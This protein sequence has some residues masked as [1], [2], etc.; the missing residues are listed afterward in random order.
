MP[1]NSTWFHL[2]NDSSSHVYCVTENKKLTKNQIKKGAE[3][4]KI[5]SKKSGKVIF[6]K[7]NNL[8]RVGPG[9]VELLDK[10]KFT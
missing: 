7:K 1:E 2:D 8:K 9:L 5:W 10:P 4:V 3:L 6:L